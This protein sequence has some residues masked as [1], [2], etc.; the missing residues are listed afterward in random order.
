[1]YWLLII[2]IALAAYVVFSLWMIKRVVAWNVVMAALTIRQMTP[3]EVQQVEFTIVGMIARLR[4][5]PN[6]FYSAS[7]PVKYAFISLAMLELGRPAIDPL[8]PFRSLR[9]PL[10][11]DKA[12][13]HIEIVR[14]KCEAKFG[15]PLD[16]LKQ[17]SP[18]AV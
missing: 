10:L 5:D 14:K 8:V 12:G 13:S 9:S 7:A 2:F 11:A 16:D 6:V 15:I 3:D 17:T 18:S 4:L 1:M